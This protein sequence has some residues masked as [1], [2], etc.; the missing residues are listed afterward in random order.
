[1]MTDLIWLLALSKV[2][3]YTWGWRI[4]IKKEPDNPDVR[5]PLPVRI[6]LS[7]LLLVAALFIALTA[8]GTYSYWVLPGMAFSTLGDLF[9]ARI[10]PLPNRL[11]GG[12]GAFSVAHVFYVTAFVQTLG[13][14][15]H[16]PGSIFVQSLF[17]YV[18]VTLAVFIFLVHNPTGKLY[19]E[20][21]I[22]F[23]FYILWIAVMA[24]FAATL[25]VNTGGWSYLVAIGALSFVISDL[26]IGV[27][28]LGEKKFPR[29]E[30]W[31][32][33]TYVLAQM[34]I[35][36]AGLHMGTQ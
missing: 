22:P 29:S 9:M 5:L 35:I 7:F 18:L 10:I 15:G 24:A 32:W 3:L 17:F 12:I 25:A 31:I 36:Y 8:P 28:V 27:T 4:A 34:C 20:I 6:T 23:L 19:K 26:I 2:V 13:E 16:A 33:L 21:A 30:L 1:M 14:R 11:Y